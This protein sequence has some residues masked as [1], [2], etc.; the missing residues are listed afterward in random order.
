MTSTHLEVYDTVDSEVP[1]VKAPE[2]QPEFQLCI[3][4][5][6]WNVIQSKGWIKSRCLDIISIRGHPEGLGV[7]LIFDESQKGVFGEWLEKLEEIKT[8]N[9]NNI[10][11]AEKILLELN[12][13]GSGVKR[14]SFQEA[15]TT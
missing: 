7:D 5:Q 15:M 1:E 12:D 9:N 4:G 13:V 8:N 6:E 14:V 10:S 3:L 11:Q 2:G